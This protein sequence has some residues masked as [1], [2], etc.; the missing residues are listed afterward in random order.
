MSSEA[1]AK[2][3]KEVVRRYH[4]DVRYVVKDARNNV[5]EQEQQQF[6]KEQVAIR[7]KRYLS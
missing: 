4:W 5:N 6:K 2:Y 1:P 3:N 7:E